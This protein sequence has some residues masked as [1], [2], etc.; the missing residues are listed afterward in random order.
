VIVIAILKNGMYFAVS[1]FEL[2][3]KNFVSIKWE[4]LYGFRV[5]SISMG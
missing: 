4:A 3:G 2:L 1:F 5:F